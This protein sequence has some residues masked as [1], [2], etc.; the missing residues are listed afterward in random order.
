[1]EPQPESQ[2]RPHPTS[3]RVPD[4]LLA[5]IDRVAATEERSR[6]NMVIRLLGEALRARGGYALVPSSPPV[7][8]LEP[9]AV[10]G[11]PGGDDFSPVEPG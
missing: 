1:M 9:A 11:S 8:G 3:F 4:A 2:I 10:G 7:P 6:S 5:E